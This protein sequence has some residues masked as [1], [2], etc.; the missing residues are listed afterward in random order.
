MH[1]RTTSSNP[2]C[3]ASSVSPART[4]R[5]SLAPEPCRRR[6]PF[7]RMKT[8]LGSHGTA[9]F[10]ALWAHARMSAGKYRAFA[11]VLLSGGR[12][13]CSVVRAA[14]FGQ[15]KGAPSG[16]PA[17]FGYVASAGL[18]GD[19]ASFAEHALLPILMLFVRI[20]ERPL[21]SGRGDPYGWGGH[22]GH[23]EAHYRAT[24]V[25]AEERCGGRTNE[26]RG[27]LSVRCQCAV[28]RR[29]AAP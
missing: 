4:S 25:P 14:A 17:K 8:L 18:A 1:G 9:P 13:V 26:R 6:V 7:A 22:E 11:S 24:V 16:R 23:Y 10:A 29:V 28:G 5:R 20:D 21:E 12:F 19:G 3:S 15:R 27:P 2:A